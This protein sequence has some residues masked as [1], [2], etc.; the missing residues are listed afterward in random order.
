MP[1]LPIP[2]MYPL[3]SSTWV[4]MQELKNGHKKNVENFIKSSAEYDTSIHMDVASSNSIL[5]R[6][7]YIYIYIYVYV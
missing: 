6:I 1:Q 3:L 5:I 7:V 2:N 4:R